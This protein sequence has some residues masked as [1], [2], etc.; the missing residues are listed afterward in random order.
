MGNTTLDRKF[1]ESTRGKVVSALRGSKRTVNELAADLKLTDNAIRAHL[2]T[3][4]RDGLVEQCGTVKG[5]RKPH[6]VYQL[7]AEARHVFPKFYHTLFN[8]LLDS[9]KARM[10]AATTAA[11]LDEVGRSF[12]G[13]RAA[14]KKNRSMNDR[15]EKAL[16][17]LQ[18]LGGSAAVVSEAG[19]LMIKSNACPLADAIKEHPETCKIAESMIQEIVGEKVREVCDRSETPRCRFVIKTS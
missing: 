19:K 4:E 10:P 9:I 3:L 5:F 2:I 7:T 16:S 15:L 6:S 17:A 11:L 8:R 18:D 1:F 13:E 12:A 14:A